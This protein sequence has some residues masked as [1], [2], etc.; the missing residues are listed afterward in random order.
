MP[1]ESNIDQDK[2]LNIAYAC[3]VKNGYRESTYLDIMKVSGYTSTEIKTYYPTKE[4]IGTGIFERFFLFTD[5]YMRSGEIDGMSFEATTA[6][7]FQLIYS[8]LAQKRNSVLALFYP[9]RHREAVHDYLVQAGNSICD[10]FGLEDD[11]RKSQIIK[12]YLKAAAENHDVLYEKLSKQ[13]E[14]D[15]NK[16]AVQHIIKFVDYIGKPLSDDSIALLEQS[17]LSEEELQQILDQLH[18]Y[19]LGNK[20]AIP[21]INDPT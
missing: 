1:S 20:S 2:I 8:F 7:A 14:I 17:L 16:L 9:L 4:D 21:W 18:Q 11:D 6:I 10:E 12:A 3:F 19:L 13:E 5:K 15:V